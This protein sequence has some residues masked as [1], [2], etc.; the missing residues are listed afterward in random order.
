MSS[1]IQN[2]GFTKTLIKENNHY[3]KIVKWNGEYDGKFANINIAINN[4]NKQKIINI[5][6]TNDEIMDILKIQPV[7][8]PLETRLSQHFLNKPIILEGVLIKNKSIKKKRHK[9]RKTRKFY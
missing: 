7:E 8:I 1:Y 5:Q 3:N 6:L 2:Y 9:K 4:N